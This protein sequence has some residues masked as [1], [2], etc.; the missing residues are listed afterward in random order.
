M[1]PN[2]VYLYIAAGLVALFLYYQ[3]IGL[4]EEN[5]KQ[6]TEISNLT[7]ATDILSKEIVLRGKLNVKLNKDKATIESKNRTLQHDLTELKTTP[8]QATCDVTAT[9]AGYA[10]RVLN[11]EHQ[12][13]KDNP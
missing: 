1:I 5:A 12:N 4:V 9:P 13:N 3:F 7:A 6:E 11:R 10:D 2:K 8:Q